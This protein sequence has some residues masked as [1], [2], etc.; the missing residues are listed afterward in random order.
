MTKKQNA[1]RTILDA[2]DGEAEE[3]RQIPG[4]EE[5]ADRISDTVTQL[6]KQS[7]LKQ[8]LMLVERL[9]NE[10]IEINRT[11]ST[12]GP[13]MGILVHTHSSRVWNMARQLKFDKDESI[14]LQK[15]E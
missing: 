10:S 7:P 15:H 3:I 4:F 1:T 8:K 9:A 13:H 6:H 12:Y 11:A 5:H 14:I 2:L